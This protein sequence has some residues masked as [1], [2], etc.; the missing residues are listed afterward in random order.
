MILLRTVGCIDEV[1]LIK[2][3]KCQ[4]FTEY[5]R[6][7]GLSHLSVYLNTPAP[8]EIALTLCLAAVN[9]KSDLLLTP[10]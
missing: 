9:V 4:G 6:A 2:S 7:T 8:G 10:K 3:Q 5:M 1:I